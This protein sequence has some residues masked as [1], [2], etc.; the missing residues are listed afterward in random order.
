MY[1]VKDYVPP[2]STYLSEAELKEEAPPVTSTQYESTIYTDTVGTPRPMNGDYLFS[3]L[4][5]PVLDD[6]PVSSSA[7]EPNRHL[8]PEF[9]K[10]W[11]NT[12]RALKDFQVEAA[13]LFDNVLVPLDEIKAV[14]GKLVIKSQTRK[15]GSLM[16][17]QFLK[18]SRLQDHLEVS[19]LFNTFL[20]QA[21]RFARVIISERCES[22][23]AQLIEDS[24]VGGV[25]GGSKYIA[26]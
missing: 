17:S 20:N 9:E 22:S 16:I 5:K 7:I 19:K 23:G 1:D 10:L 13:A 12:G 4:I 26:G 11:S 25:A 14:L 8:E 3:P 6:L 15:S 18:A 2:V 21:E 24:K